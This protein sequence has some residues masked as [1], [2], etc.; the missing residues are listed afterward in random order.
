MGTTQFVQFMMLILDLHKKRATLQ[1]EAKIN[2]MERATTNI[3]EKTIAK[4]QIMIERATQK[5][6][7]EMI[8][9]ILKK[10]NIQRGILCI[11]LS[12]FQVPSLSMQTNNYP[13]SQ[14]N[15]LRQS[16][17]RVGILA[18]CRTFI[19]FFLFQ[20]RFSFEMID[21]DKDDINEKTN[22]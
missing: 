16:G 6:Y 13:F 11:M 5:N 21:R 17:K 19:A 7:R 8:K 1:K 12:V 22:D 2:F 9:D 15:D 14:I 3:R 18:N 10:I 4:N 20:R